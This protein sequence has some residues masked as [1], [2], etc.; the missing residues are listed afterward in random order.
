MVY[1]I[2]VCPD[3]PNLASGPPKTVSPAHAPVTTWPVH[4]QGDT[5]ERRGQVP[6]GAVHGVV[7]VHMPCGYMGAFTGMSLKHV[8][9]Q[10]SA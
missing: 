3:M 7:W 9:W 10:K 6:G 2:T 5:A 4:V 1:G 8:S